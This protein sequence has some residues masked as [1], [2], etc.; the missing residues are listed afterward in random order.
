MSLR[1]KL[2][3]LAYKLLP[4]KAY[5]KIGYRYMYH[6]KLNLDNPT[7]LSEKWYWLKIYY[8][9]HYYD[10]IR[11]CY[12]KY[13]VRE[14]LK[15]KGCDKYLTQILGVY[16]SADDIDFD[17]LPNQF[18]LKITQSSG[19][20][21]I[22]HDKSN[23]NFNETRRIL[24]LWL[25]E[26]NNPKN[27]NRTEESYYFTGE[28]KIICEEYLMD[29]NGE[30][31]EDIKLFCLNGKVC[32]SYI[33]FDSVDENGNKKEKYDLNVYD[34]EWELLPINWGSNHNYNKEIKVNKPYM[35]E[36][37]VSVAE[38]MAEDF[39]FV[40]VDLYCTGSHIYFGELTWCPT[41]GNSFVR[42]PEYDRIFGEML[43]LPKE[44]NYEEENNKK[45][46]P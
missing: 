40:R 15:N 6:R 33:T 4:I 7:L 19:Y 38:K 10:T 23:L 41:G 45:V 37:L 43:M 1:N 14:Y 18:V 30:I 2:R 44:K 3:V 5:L 46:L 24:N 34:R 29:D 16:D 11:Q 8:K 31:V 42:E 21:I 20:N 39:P 27:Q 28:A 9:N 17:K 32:F 36:E 22:C 13:T 26:V 12:D 35:Y 25:K